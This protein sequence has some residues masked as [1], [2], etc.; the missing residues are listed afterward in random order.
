M[1]YVERYADKG[2]DIYL[3]EYTKDEE[4]ISEIAEYCRAK[5]F[6]YYVSDSIELD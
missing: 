6:D 4:L 2:A 5:G 1:S 3:L